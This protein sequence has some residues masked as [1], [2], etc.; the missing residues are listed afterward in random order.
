MVRR[1]ARGHAK[2]TTPPLFF[3]T[4]SVG[5]APV[6]SRFVCVRVLFSRC[7]RGLS[8]VRP[9]HEAQFVT[10]LI[11]FSASWQS[12]QPRWCAVESM[13]GSV[14]TTGTTQYHHCAMDPSGSGPQT[15]T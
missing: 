13:G 4:N 6:G 11:F 2:R 14:A 10:R 9:R 3:V 8:S 12:P 1:D 15:Q 5:D 7:T